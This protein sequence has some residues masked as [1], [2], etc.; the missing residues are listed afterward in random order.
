MLFLAAKAGL[1]E[2]F[3]ILV[4]AGGQ[5]L[6]YAICLTVTVYLTNYKIITVKTLDDK[7][8]YFD[9]KT[10]KILK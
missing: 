5:L 3:G 9:T 7:G 10:K 2:K 1:F 8:T 4:F 6:F